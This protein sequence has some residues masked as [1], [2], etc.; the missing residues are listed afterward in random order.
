MWCTL[1]TSPPPPPTVVLI[2][3]SMQ[4]NIYYMGCYSFSE[5]YPIWKFPFSIHFAEWLFV[6]ILIYACCLVKKPN[7]LYV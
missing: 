2:A 5:M 4:L 7:F 6:N 3:I 1:Y